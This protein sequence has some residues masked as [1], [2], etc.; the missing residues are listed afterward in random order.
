MVEERIALTVLGGIEVEVT[1][2]Q[3]NRTSPKSKMRMGQRGDEG[4]DR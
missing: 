4:M 2:D 1:E 3:E